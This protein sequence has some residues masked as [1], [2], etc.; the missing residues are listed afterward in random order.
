[1]NSLYEIKYLKYKKKY[2]M[3]KNSVGGGVKVLAEFKAKAEARKAKDEAA[4]A[5]EAKARAEAKAA[6]TSIAINKQ[7]EVTTQPDAATP[8]L[9]EKRIENAVCKIM[10]N[11][12][13]VKMMPNPTTKELEKVDDSWNIRHTGKQ[14]NNKI[15]K[16]AIFNKKIESENQ[17]GPKFEILNNEMSNIAE[18]N[19]SIIRDYYSK[20]IYFE[21]PLNCKIL[22]N[23]ITYIDSSKE[24][25]DNTAYINKDGEKELPIECDICQFMSPNPRFQYPIDDDLTKDVCLECVKLYLFLER[26]KV[27]KEMIVNMF[28]D[29]FSTAQTIPTIELPIKLQYKYKGSTEKP[30]KITLNN[31]KWWTN[32]MPVNAEANT[33]VKAAKF[34]AEYEAREKARQAEY[35][36]IQAEYEAREKARQ[37]EYEAR[38]AELKAEYQAREKA[39]QAKLEARNAEIE[40]ILKA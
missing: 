6:R 20:I 34:D 27:G 23:N 10:H 31:K 4:E 3:L 12:T 25:Y 40:A 13:K 38:Q 5:A 26:N 7:L 39:R 15:D 14:L 16:Y 35:E 24:D 8:E 37:A 1:M 19:S 33:E 29:R 9:V 2:L 36:A 18:K 30:Y 32:V 17:E 11:L 28:I 22:K 21:E